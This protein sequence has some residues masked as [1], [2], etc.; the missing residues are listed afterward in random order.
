MALVPVVAIVA[1]FAV[2][3][4]LGFGGSEM[5]RAQIQREVAELLADI[6]QDGTTLGSPN[7]PITLVVFADLECPTVKRFVTTDFPLIIETWVR[8]GKV[9]LDY[10]SL[11]TDTVNEETFF[12]Q[13]VAALAAGKQD[14]LWNFALTFVR[15]QGQERTGYANEEFFTDIASQVPGLSRA[16]W[17]HDREDLSLSRKVAR[18]VRSAH[19]LD[20]R[21]TPSF[22]VSFS[23][24]DDGSGRSVDRESMKEELESNL[25][26]TANALAEEDLGDVPAVGFLDLEK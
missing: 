3:G 22:L 17:R 13:E 18:A 7:A 20:M 10:R 8:T 4:V 5:D 23:K 9:K 16:Q 11:E 2:V 15:E 21:S 6:P 25:G 14:R 24:K 1:I 19:V 12:E 26:L